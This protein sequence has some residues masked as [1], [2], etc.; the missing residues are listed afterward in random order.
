MSADGFRVYIRDPT[1]GTG[2]L[3]DNAT[4]GR[5]AE[6]RRELEAE[7]GEK[8]Q[9][10][11]IG[12]G[13]A[14]AAYFAELVSDPHKAASLGVSALFAGRSSKTSLR[15]GC[16][17][18]NSSL[19]SFTVSRPLIERGRP[20]LFTRRSWTRWTAFQKHISLQA[21]QSRTGSTFLTRWNFPTPGRLRQSTH[22]LLEEFNAP[23]ST[24]LRSSQTGGNS[25][26]QSTALRSHSFKNNLYPHGV[27]TAV[28]AQ[29]LNLLHHLCPIS[30]APSATN[31]RAGSAK[32]IPPPSIALRVS[33]QTAR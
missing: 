25:G 20:S 7:Y 10:T 33:N 31:S 27:C 9:F 11:S 5:S 29:L 15:G 19:N 2:Y 26:S 17:Y 16:G 32:K 4:T 28:P 18:T 22:P 1:R 30:S 8:F 21:S 14:L 13:A 3:S 24:F 23:R 12:T 6:F